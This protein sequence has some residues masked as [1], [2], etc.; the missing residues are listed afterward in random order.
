MEFSQPVCINILSRHSSPPQID[1]TS[2]ARW[3][4]ALRDKGNSSVLLIIQ[5]Q[6][7]VSIKAPSLLTVRVA[8]KTWQE[9]LDCYSNRVL[10]T[11]TFHTG[12]KFKYAKFNYD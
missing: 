6:N 11:Q 3:R 8:D 9:A 10:Q 7:I 1:V 5:P 4:K 12:H 2:V